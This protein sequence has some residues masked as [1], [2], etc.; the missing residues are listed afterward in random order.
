MC[1]KNPCKVKTQTSALQIHLIKARG[2]PLSGRGATTR[3]FRARFAER[4]HCESSELG[5]GTE[6]CLK[7]LARRDRTG[8]STQVKYKTL[9]RVPTF[10][11]TWELNTR[12]CHLPTCALDLPLASK[13][14]FANT[15]RTNKTADTTGL[16]RAHHLSARASFRGL[17]LLSCT[18]RLLEPGSAGAPPDF[19]RR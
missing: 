12:L 2:N 10:P 5:L 7:W 11:F 9:N 8:L 3:T 13:R 19:D 16:A 14:T 18:P 17:L 4:A 15:R 1:A 6:I